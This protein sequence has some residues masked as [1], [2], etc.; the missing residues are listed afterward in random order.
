MI[1]ILNEAGL[2][3]REEIA[4]LLGS[5]RLV[6]QQVGF[7]SSMYLKWAQFGSSWLVYSWDGVVRG[8]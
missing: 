4:V 8:N 1:Y 7:D 5:H 6:Q 3:F 2:I